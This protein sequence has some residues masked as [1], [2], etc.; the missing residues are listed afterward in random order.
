MAD[1]RLE[2][3]RARILRAVRAALADGPLDRIEIRHLRAD[4]SEPHAHT[5]AAD[6]IS[7]KGVN[8]EG[9][10]DELLEHVQEDASIFSEG[11]QTYVILF[12]KV[13]ERD[14]ARRVPVQWQSKQQKTAD[15]VMTSE[16]AN[17]KGL[18][19]MSMRFAN[20]MFQKALSSLEIVHRE[21]GELRQQVTAYHE[22]EFQVKELSQDL[23]DRQ[24]ERDRKRRRDEMVD[25]EFLT[26]MRTYGPHLMRKL[27]P[28]APAMPALPAAAPNGASGS[29][30]AATAS[31]AS[32]GAA[33]GAPNSDP[34]LARL[35]AV[36]AE[37]ASIVVGSL[38]PT[39]ARDLRVRFSG[40]GAP[41][42]FDRL[43]ATVEERRVEKAS[44]RALVDALVG[45]A[46]LVPMEEQAHVL[47]VVQQKPAAVMTALR[48]L[49]DAITTYVQKRAPDQAPQEQPAPRAQDQQKENPNP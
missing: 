1:K 35:E 27:L 42:A 11:V 8:A 13:G 41:E 26:V 48:D 38:R 4:G 33:A 36:I 18:V 49:N 28:G 31:G 24:V 37:D 47:A 29:N 20:D 6:S 16:P 15:D 9:I 43:I 39:E 12:Y 32:N 7:G 30:G 44:D 46:T 3:T 40:A 22:R 21:N 14:Y 17:E 25:R 2:E 34:E 19:A 10:A 23:L 45:W 5:L